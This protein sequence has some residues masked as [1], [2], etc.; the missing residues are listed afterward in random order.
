MV[1]NSINS[2]RAL[3]L[4]IKDENRP[5]RKR[6]NNSLTYKLFNQQ[7]WNV[8]KEAKKMIPFDIILCSDKPAIIESDFFIKQSGKNFGER[9]NNAIT[10]TFNYGYDEL[11]IIGN[12]SPDLS[13]NHIIESFNNISKNVV[14][15]PSSDGGIYLLGLSKNMYERPIK[16]RWNTSHVLKDVSSNFSKMNIFQLETLKDIDSESDL[17][18]WLLSKSVVSGV[19]NEFLKNAFLELKKQVSRISLLST[20]QNIYRQHTQKAPPS[21]ISY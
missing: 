8:V 12:D 9:F 3:I 21:L 18:E 7:I 6:F 19:F 10:K 1:N 13:A 11:I 2:K 16:A 4:F 5:N 14:I 20:E 15:G 17:Y